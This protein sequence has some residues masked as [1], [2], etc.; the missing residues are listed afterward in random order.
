MIEEPKPRR[1]TQK[2]TP[3]S[4]QP[5]YI[6]ISDWMIRNPGG[7][8]TDCARA[9]NR[10][11]A[12]V[13]YVANSDMFREFHAQR[14]NMW[15]EGHD[16]AIMSKMTQVAEKSLDVILSKL[17]KQSDRIPM[18]LVTEIATA[19]LDRLGYAPNGP[20]I[21]VPVQV[22]IDNRQQ[23]VSVPV[24]AAA[25]EEARDALR[26]AEQK[27]AIDVRSY[28]RLEPVSDHGV[29]SDMIEEAD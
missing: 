24:T 22:N 20:G 3:Q 1:L 9:L 14:R 12:T 7:D 26:A 21:G 19:S 2:Y 13:R 25:L 4:W 8:M 16:F 10:H 18:Q 23:T 28:E 11:H 6:A 5:W 15:R 27:K 17:E 29:V